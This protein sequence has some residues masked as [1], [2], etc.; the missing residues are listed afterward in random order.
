MITK[1]YSVW[2]WRDPIKTLMAG[3]RATDSELGWSKG[4][5]VER[6]Y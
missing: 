1:V 5:R 3:L 2:W 6:V 4:V